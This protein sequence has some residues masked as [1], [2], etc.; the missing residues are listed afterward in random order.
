MILHLS[1]GLPP[2]YRTAAMQLYW[3]AF[4]G[5]LGPIMG[6]KRRALAYLHR[7]MRPDQCIAAFQ[8][9]ALVGIVGYHT[10]Q[11]SFAGGDSD[12]MRAIYGW[13]GSLWRMAILLRL[14][15]TAECG[16]LLI[17]GFCVMDAARG[18]GIGTA[19]L[20]Q[21]IAHAQDQRFTGVQ[22][23]VASSN[24]RAQR[25]YARHGFAKIGAQP[26]GAL[27]IVF[28]FAAVLRMARKI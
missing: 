13:A 1:H 21:I 20:A 19:L 22:L 11:G 24:L 8:G 17:D 26:I 9:D 10:A 4:G 12:D 23:D 16:A 2:Q 7:V 28:G 18:Q 14:G 27:R 6:P 15:H 3:Q 5:K 25:F